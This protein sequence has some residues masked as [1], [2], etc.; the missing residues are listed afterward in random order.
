MIQHVIRTV[1]ENI[2]WLANAYGVTPQSIASANGFSYSMSSIYGWLSVNGGTRQA[3]ADVPTG[4]HWSFTPGMVV[5]VPTSKPSLSPVIS[6]EDTIPGGPAV[7]PEPDDLSIG[8]EPGEPGVPGPAQA[9]AG[10][11]LTM[12]LILGVAA[13]FFLSGSGK[14]KA[15]S[16]SRKRSTRKSTK[17]STKRKTS[18][19]RR[20]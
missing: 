1:N 5:N 4:Y 14:G 16:K 20:R 19:R 2:E 6:I 8:P 18:R 12:W 13:Y 3:A 11:G 17:R 10:G 7:E 15:K 9:A